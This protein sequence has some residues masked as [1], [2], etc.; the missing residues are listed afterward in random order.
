M[1][2]QE[3]IDR[4]EAGGYLEREEWAAL[5]ADFDESDRLY[6][7]QKA[8]ATANRYFGNR[9]YI[10]GLIEFTS[11]CKNDCYYCGLRRSN[12]RAARYR[13]TEEEILTCCET[14]Y[15][16]GFRTFVL[17]GGEDGGFSDE[18]LCALIGAI[19][20]RWPDC[21]LTLSVGEREADVY[22][23]FYAAGADR[24][25]LRHETAD[26]AH[27]GR[28]HPPEMSPDHR[29]ACLDTLKAIGYQTGCGFMVGSPGQTPET[30]AA[31]MM[32][33]GKLHP[34]MVGIG[35]F[36][37][38]KDTP[39]GR[40]RAGSC[41]LTLFLISLVRIMEKNVLLPAT[42]ALGTALPGGREA[43]ILAGANVV[44]PNLS[45][46]GIREKYALYDG[47]KCTGA[48]AAEGIDGLRERLRRLGYE[49]VSG[50]G[51]WKE[52]K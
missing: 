9:I 6:A 17:Q 22:R 32:L 25:L 41:E 48:E 26:A 3:V 43:G 36:L 16:L 28:L 52:C 15:G 45:P 8:V 20:E 12:T 13:L 33:I 11:Y 5:L 51:D 44:M 29:I 42:T 21:A 1:R 30:L 24:Y 40:E 38:H 31:D 23:R 50:R 14:G 2:N 27:Y 47:K 7:A 35:P 49:V 34:H 39:F 18:R 10:R 19:K 46:A 37:P 4:L